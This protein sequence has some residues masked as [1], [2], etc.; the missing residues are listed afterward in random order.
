MEQRFDDPTGSTEFDQGLF[1]DLPAPTPSPW[2]PKK[3]KMDKLKINYHDLTKEDT[4]AQL[5]S[6]KTAMTGNLIYPL[7]IP[8]DTAQTATIALLDGAMS[9]FATADSDWDVAHAKLVNALD[10]S[11]A[12]LGQRASNCNSVTPGDKVKLSTTALPLYTTG[13]SV[14]GPTPRVENVKL[15]AGDIVSTVD[16]SWDS[17][18][19]RAHSY[20]VQSTPVLTSD[21]NLST[22]K[23]EDSVTKSN[24]TIGPF[25]SGTRIWVRVRALGPNG[26]GDWSDPATLIVP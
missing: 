19:K 4:L 6:H 10:A 7:P 21:P 9:A 22:W 3:G 11:Q 8:D 1:Y 18:L 2:V 23:N 17:L 25:T 14:S 15:T 12:F 13:H 24:T 26:N 16:P 20:Q 5:K